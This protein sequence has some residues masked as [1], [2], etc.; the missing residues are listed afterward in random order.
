VLDASGLLAQGAAVPALSLGVLAAGLGAVAPG[1]RGCVALDWPAS[2]LVNFVL[3]DYAYY[4]NH[5]LLHGRALWRWHAV[6]HTAPAMD[7]LVTSRNSLWSHAL[8]LYL[9]VNGAALFLLGD[10]RGF[11]AAA[12][13]TALLDLWRH[14]PLG[15][16]PDSRLARG[17]AAVLI[18]PH[19]HAWHHSAERPGCNFGANLSWWDRLHGTYWSPAAAPARM[20]TARAESATRL[21]L[22]PRGRL[23]P[24]AGPERAS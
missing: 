10:P 13:L 2:F 14:S 5:R 23:V 17:V 8:V 12:A 18:T 21:L 6:H 24:V 11:A 9:W 20:G 15:P 1:W 7:V 22:W 19:E 4:W 16:A 3:V